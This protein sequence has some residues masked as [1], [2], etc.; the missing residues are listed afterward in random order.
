[1]S[2]S[3]VREDVALADDARAW[4]GA[5]EQV[6][7]TGVQRSFE[8][9]FL[10]DSFWRDMVSLTWDT[11][12]FWG[13]D[14]IWRALSE[15]AAS[16]GFSNLRLDDERPGPRIAE[17]LG[18]PVV[19]LFFAF[20]TAVGTGKGFARLTPDTSADFGLRAW[21]IATALVKLNCAPEPVTR[22]PKLGFDPAYPGQTWAEWAA[23]KSDF[24]RRDPDVLIIGGSHSGLSVGA[25]FE[26]KGASYL[27]VEKNR[28]PGDTW[29]N[30][31]ESLALHTP[32]WM[33]D[34]PYIPLPE[35][36][37]MFLPKD[38]WADWLDCYATLMNLNFWGSTEAL[39][40][41]FDEAARVWEVALRLADGSVRV[42]HPKHLVLAVGG[43]GGKPKIPELP[44][45]NEFAGEVLHSSAFKSG[46]A[47]QGKRVMV[48]GTSTTGHD[49]CLD[50][51]HKGAFPTM[52]QRGPACVVNIDEVVKFSADYGTVPVDEADQ[53]RSSMSLPL[54]LKRAKAYT[55]TTEA[56]HAELHVGLRNAGQKLT[57]G[58]DETGWT[59]KLFREV[60]G[61][62][63]NV[64]A[65]EAIVDGNIA[66]L[67]FERIERFV[68]DGVLLTDG[69]VA[70]FDAV[71]LC[72]GYHDLSEDIAALLGAEVAQKVGRCI[73][74]AEDGEY[75]TMSRPTA[76]PHLWVINGG[77]VDSRKSSDILA[78]QV[79]AQMEGLV[80]TL[81][82]QPDGSVKAL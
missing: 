28:K 37:P 61:Y 65:S 63:L 32:T 26:R 80:P 68:R 58:D 76:Q 13:R 15:H 9:L 55:L 34:L 6:L 79:I 52:A 12:Q 48:V 46:N 31:Y 59:M 23:A 57:I 54:L 69:R 78:L 56:S 14:A 29:R 43:A 11:C 60:R 62:Y 64:G 66:M 36:W 39:N 40:A 25:R 67:D 81:V 74:V 1:M 41:S 53:R 75:R 30:R 18:E 8:E 35:G 47:F 3:D 70:L 51:Y 38:R 7:S 17:F 2:V 22:H 21:M 27:I 82:R 71:V 77:I 33:N 45:L 42:M 50:L 24:S 49:I 73:G 44:G 20:D 19:E 10:A 72:T 4:I 16:A 5:L